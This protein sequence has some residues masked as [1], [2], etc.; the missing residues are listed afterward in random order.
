M[1]TPVTRTKAQI[2]RFYA[3]V[4]GEDFNLTVTQEEA[5]RAALAFACS[6]VE[7]NAA[8]ACAELRNKW[9]DANNEVVRLKQA[10]ADAEEEIG[11][12]CTALQDMEAKQAPTA[13]AIGIPLNGTP[14]QYVEVQPPAAPAEQRRRGRKPGSKNV[15]K[16]AP[17][18]APK[19]TVNEIARQLES[20]T[21]PQVATIDR[22]L[23]CADDDDIALNGTLRRTEQVMTTQHGMPVRVTRQFIEIR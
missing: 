7:D 1:D 10:R 14:P 21:V 6:E 8:T 2:I 22:A 18:D 5:V 17:K 15:S 13:A 4:L 20:G 11:R 23:V 16:D 12:L 3:G 19:L 9:V